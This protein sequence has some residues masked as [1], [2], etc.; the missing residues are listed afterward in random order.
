MLDLASRV[1]YTI[2][3]WAPVLVFAG[4]YFQR[5]P[6][7]T[8][9]VLYN[10]H[11]ELITNGGYLPYERTARP[12]L[13]ATAAPTQAVAA[14]HVCQAVTAVAQRVSLLRLGIKDV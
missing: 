8:C 1:E 12:T 14:Q 4:R 9:S 6:I 3:Y 7:L 13:E 5:S 2:L 10:I 11:Y